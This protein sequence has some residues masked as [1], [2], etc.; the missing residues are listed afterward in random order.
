[1][2]LIAVMYILTILTEDMIQA[3]YAIHHCS[4]YI[5]NTNTGE[6]DLVQV[7]PHVSYDE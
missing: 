2:K 3:T 6:I 1:M 7:L 5:N 4:K